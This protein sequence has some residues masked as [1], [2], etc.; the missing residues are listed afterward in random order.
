[1]T[2]ANSIAGCKKASCGINYTW[3]TNLK[4]EIGMET[5]SVTFHKNSAV[6]HLTIEKDKEIVKA[7]M[8]TKREEF[9]NLEHDLRDHMAEVNRI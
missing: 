2:K 4:K 1:M 8:K 6:A 5:G 9:P 7:I 3:V